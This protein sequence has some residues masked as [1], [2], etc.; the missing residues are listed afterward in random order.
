MSKKSRDTIFIWFGGVVS[1]RISEITIKTLRSKQSDIGFSKLRSEIV[2]LADELSLGLLSTHSY[3]ES[4]IKITKS[5]LDID[6][7]EELIPRWASLNKPVMK[8]LNSIP[9]KY[10]KWL[11]SDYPES[12]YQVIASRENLSSKYPAKRTIFVSQGDL[13]EMVPR[14]F[15]Y[16]ARVSSRSLDECIL[17]DSESSRAVAAV[18][19][20]LSSIIYVY[21]DRLEHEFAL[22]GILETE[23][24]VLHPDTSKRVDI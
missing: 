8:L 5:D 23:E 9:D 22:R 3:C 21:P 24:E 11:V 10:E 18:R 14:V 6:T 2:K 17:I 12:W 7:L 4:V 16:L 19:Y 1:E 15:D 20:G 13:R